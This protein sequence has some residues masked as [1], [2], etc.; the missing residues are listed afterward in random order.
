MSHDLADPQKL[1]ADHLPNRLRTFMGA[2]C[3]LVVC[4]TASSAPIPLMSIYRDTLA[5]SNA[6][7]ANSIVAYFLG[8]ILTLVF[9]AR[10]SNYFGRKPVVLLT[11]II[12]MSAS[13]TFVVME[14]VWAFNLG[15]FLQGLSC[16][17][18]SS[19]AMSWVVDAA[20][21]EKRWLGTAVTAAG[22]NIGLC[23]GTLVTGICIEYH[24]FDPTSLFMLFMALIALV[25]IL[26]A[27]GNETVQFGME[28]LLATLIPKIAI[29]RRLWR[30]F[31][32][33]SAGYIGT[34]GMGSFFQGFIAIISAETFGVQSTLIA[35]IC[36]LILMIPNA[37]TGLVI[38]R[39]YAVNAL[40][41][42]ITFFAIGGT[43]SFL[44]YG[45]HLPALFL[46]AVAICGACNGGT[47]TSGLKLVLQDTTLKERA[48]VISG[49]YLLA[50]VGAGIPNAVVGM[51]P[52]DTPVIAMSPGYI[53][54]MLG[55]WTIV[56]IGLWLMSRKPNEAEKLRLEH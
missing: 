26:V 38:G 28:P 14:N 11:L 49:I 19:A 6:D 10:L 20:P 25:M 7:V 22:P 51:M 18:A 50:Y 46:I 52:D 30:L 29:P 41:F 31:I 17:L 9:F 12:A 1:T 16:G 54:W 35:A 15:R 2:V 33:A 24:L 21:L 5:L 27:T 37:T 43:F 34:W 53:G 32:I 47:C 39:F 40:R 56:M 45:W 48:G 36:Y 4:F 3:T 55:A 44:A 13:F 23:L 42:A 8:C